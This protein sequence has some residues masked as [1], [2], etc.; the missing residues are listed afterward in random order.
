[1]ADNTV[2]PIVAATSSI[3]AAQAPIRVA[4]PNPSPAAAASGNEVPEGFQVYADFG[5]VYASLGTELL[6]Q[7]G[8]CTISGPQTNEGTSEVKV[9][10][11]DKAKYWLIPMLVGR[12]D[13]DQRDYRTGK[14]IEQV[15]SIEL[16]L[17]EKDYQAIKDQIEAGFTEGMVI[18][19]RRGGVPAYDF[20]PTAAVNMICNRLGVAS[21]DLPLVKVIEKEGGEFSYGEARMRRRAGQLVEAGRTQYLTGDMTDFINGQAATGLFGNLQ[22]RSGAAST[23]LNTTGTEQRGGFFGRVRNFIQS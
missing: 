17:T 13:H 3:G 5:K 16:Y 21:T 23:N 22:Q 1:M 8:F 4:A 2:N 14:L 20:P 6:V 9:F 12:P 18:G 19:A 15:G 11:G 7:T 10:P